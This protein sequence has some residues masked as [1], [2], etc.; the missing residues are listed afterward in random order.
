MRTHLPCKR[1]RVGPC[2][3]ALFQL[4]TPWDWFSHRPNMEE[5]RTS[6][7]P[8][9]RPNG[10]ILYTHTDTH[11]QTKVHS[12]NK[13]ISLMWSQGGHHLSQRD[14]NQHICGYYGEYAVCEQLLGC[15]GLGFKEYPSLIPSPWQQRKFKGQS[16]CG[17]SSGSSGGQTRRETEW[18]SGWKWARKE[19]YSAEERD[20]KRETTQLW[21]KCGGRD[22]VKE[23]WSLSSIFW[24]WTRA[25]FYYLKSDVYPQQMNTSKNMSSNLILLYY[26]NNI[27]L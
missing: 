9:V 25:I 1:P 2:Q 8:S 15:V 23:C 7:Y 27:V 18:E 6:V 26:H 17:Y 11:T 14:I 13:S 21:G 19:L 24:L 4:F 12:R 20:R 3:L 16:N 5:T 10:T 22:Q